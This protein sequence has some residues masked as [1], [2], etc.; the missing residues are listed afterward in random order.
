MYMIWEKT[1]I[2]IRIRLLSKNCAILNYSVNDVFQMNFFYI[3]LI[4]VPNIIFQCSKEP[5]IVYRQPMLWVT[6]RK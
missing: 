4:C 2:T 5:F 1:L 6:T 3:L